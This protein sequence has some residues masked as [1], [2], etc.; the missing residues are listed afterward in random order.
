MR[1]LRLAP[2]FAGAEDRLRKMGSGFGEYFW[3]RLTGHSEICRQ[4]SLKEYSEN[5]GFCKCYS[6]RP[7]AE[8]MIL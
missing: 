7:A 3:R 1:P 4:P 2:C 5:V 8:N 6:Y